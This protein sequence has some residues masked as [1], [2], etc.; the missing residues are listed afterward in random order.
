[1]LIN[2]TV[3]YD[4]IALPSS[5]RASHAWSNSCLSYHHSRPLARAFVFCQMMYLVSSSDNRF[6]PTALISATFLRPISISCVLHDIYPPSLLLCL[7]LS[8]YLSRLCSISTPFLAYVTGRQPL[9]FSPHNWHVTPFLVLSWN[10]L[11]R[12]LVP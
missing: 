2:G 11:V 5:T 9:G 4:L 10:I 6:H 8:P 7:I 3:V 1:M 12:D